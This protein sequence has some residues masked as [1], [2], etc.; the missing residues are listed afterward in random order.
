[1]RL[2]N[3]GGEMEGWRI[4]C[5]E[6]GNDRTWRAEKANGLQSFFFFLVEVL[7]V[8]PSQ[9]KSLVWM[10]CSPHP[11]SMKSNNEWKPEQM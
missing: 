11:K 5:E 6:E 9:A 1:M 4:G 7:K 3:E 2:R 8:L 10:E